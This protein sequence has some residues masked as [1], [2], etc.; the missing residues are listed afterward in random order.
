MNLLRLT[1]LSIVFL[2]VSAFSSQPLDER[3]IQNGLPQSYDDLWKTFAKCKVH[4][5]P[6]NYT[7]TI[8]FT[9]EVQA[10]DGKPF[11]ISG[12]MLPLESKE[13][14]PTICFPNARPPAHSAHRANPTKLLKFFPKNR[15]NGMKESSPFLV[16]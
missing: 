4:L 5:E 16:Q 12:L 8:K 6:T 13:K 15:S 1:F 3:K 2:T 7:Y 11:T 10:M 14:F 9:P